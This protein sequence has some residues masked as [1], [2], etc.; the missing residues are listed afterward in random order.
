MPEGQTISNVTKGLSFNVN[1]GSSHVNVLVQVE[2][3]DDGQLIISAKYG[4]EEIGK[5]ITSIANYKIVSR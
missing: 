2:E 1:G 5:R 4:E 3:H